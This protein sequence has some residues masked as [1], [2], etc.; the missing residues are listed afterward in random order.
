MAAKLTGARL[1]AAFGPLVDAVELVG[2]LVVVGL[3]TWQMAQGRLTLGGLLAFV[4]YLSQ[5]YGPVRSL[6][7]LTNTIY[8]ASAGAERISELL[9]STTS[10]PEHADATDLG[11]AHGVVQLDHVSFTYPDATGPTLHDVCLTASPGEVLALVGPSGAGKST[12]ARLILRMYDPDAGAVRL[13]GHDVRALRL[14]ALRGNI[15]LLLQETLIFH[16]TVGENIAYGRNGASPEELRR[17][18][19]LAD[20]DGFAQRLAD[21]YDTVIGE[22]GRLVGTFSLLMPPCGGSP[23]DSASGSRSPGP[24]CETPR[25]SSWTSRRPDSTKRHGP[26]RRAAAPAHDG[27]YDD[28]HR[29]RPPHHRDGRPSAHAERRLPRRQARHPRREQGF[30]AHMSVT[31]QRSQPHQLLAGQEVAPG[32][33]VVEHLSRGNELDVYAAWSQERDAPAS[34]SCYDP[35]GSTRPRVETA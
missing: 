33:L 7:R 23:A 10:V 14:G 16:G 9:T 8:S 4:A 19:R 32:Y 24:W 1:N 25:C 26:R 11:R 34:S 35:T 18:T 30:G 12:V 21:G 22:R 5:V 20:V 27:P 3:G 17:A 15:A 2:V 6:S 13:D 28:R 31:L 29:T